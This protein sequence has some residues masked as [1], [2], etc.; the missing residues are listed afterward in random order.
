MAIQ[1]AS[2]LPALDFGRKNMEAGRKAFD[3][4]FDG[5]AA[6]MRNA[7]EMH[8]A[9]QDMEAR[10][11]LS[12]NGIEL[13]EG[14]DAYRRFIKETNNRKLAQLAK[15]GITE[16][17][18]KRMGKSIGDV[19]LADFKSAMMTDYSIPMNVS[20]ESYSDGISP[21]SHGKNWEAEYGGFTP[22][23]FEQSLGFTPIEQSLGQTRR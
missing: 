1:I 23:G 11:W 20:F 22:I 14:E 6:N 8:D 4:G 15:A 3:D 21:E 12:E 13:A 5:L 19:D 9:R 17:D 18:L 10:E 16:D 2:A 7:K